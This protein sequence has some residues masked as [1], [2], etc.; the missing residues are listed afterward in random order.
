VLI[1]LFWLTID[2]RERKGLAFWSDTSREFPELRLHGAT[3][4][5]HHAGG[6]C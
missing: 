2:A 4:E 3:G 5:E 1:L 6:R